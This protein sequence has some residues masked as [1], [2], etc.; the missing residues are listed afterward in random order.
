MFSEENEFQD[1]YCESP[2][3]PIENKAILTKRSDSPD[4]IAA[5]YKTALLKVKLP[6]FTPYSCMNV[7]LIQYSRVFKMR[8]KG[9]VSRHVHPHKS[10]LRHAV[11]QKRIRKPNGK[12]EVGRIK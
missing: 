8:A 6:I 3:M 10:I 2:K 9:W 4:S 5:Y 1:F 7:N 11:A 12:F